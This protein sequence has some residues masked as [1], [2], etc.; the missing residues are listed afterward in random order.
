M[1]DDRQAGA[2]QS[3]FPRGGAAESRLVRIALGVSGGVVGSRGGG[4]R[5]SSCAPAATSR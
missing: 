1:T 3:A 2:T 5:S 4:S